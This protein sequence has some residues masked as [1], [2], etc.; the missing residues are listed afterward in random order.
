MYLDTID[1]ST[2]PTW[3]DASVVCSGA[4]YNII[5]ARSNLIRASISWEDTLTLDRVCY[6]LN[7]ANATLSYFRPPKMKWIMHGHYLGFTW[8]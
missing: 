4:P 6:L 7:S 1:T 2:L 3:D 8:L 5:G